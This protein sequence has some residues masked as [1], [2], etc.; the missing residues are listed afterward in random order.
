MRSTWRTIALNMSS[1][2]PLSGYC[3][4]SRVHLAAISPD[5]GMALPPMAPMLN[6]ASWISQA[7]CSVHKMAK[8]CQRLAPGQQAVVAQ[9]HGLAIAHA[10]QQARAL[11]GMDGDAFE[12]GRA[13]V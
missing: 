1:P 12:I 11:F 3:R 2:P 8:V 4:A 6:V 5:I 10:G 9:N 7:R 13:H